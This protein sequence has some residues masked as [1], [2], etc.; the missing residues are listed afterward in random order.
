[1]M[2]TCS[3]DNLVTSDCLDIPAGLTDL[4][5]QY[6][7]FPEFRRALI[8]AIAD[9]PELAGWSAEGEQD[10]GVMLLEM[11]AYVLDVTQ[12]YD[13]QITQEFFLGT[14][15]RQVS[16]E[17]LVKLLG[18]RPRPAVSACVLLTAEADGTEPVM[19]PIGTAFRSD[20][21]GEEAPQV[22]STLAE[23]VIL[24]GRNGWPLAPIPGETYPGR[25]LFSE[26]DAGVPKS[27]MMAFE[28]AGGADHADAIAGVETIT[29]PDGARYR[30]VTLD[31]GAPPF[32]GRALA[33]IKPW[34]M[35]L[36]VG[37]TAFGNAV[38]GGKLI[39]DGLY[40][41]IRAGQIVVIETPDL[42]E[43][44]VI[45]PNGVD[46]TGVVV[47][48]TPALTNPE[49]AAQ[50]ITAPATRIALPALAALLL[51]ATPDFVLHVAPIAVGR[52][53]APARTEIALGDVTGGIAL[54]APR[55][56][57]LSEQSGDFVLTGHGPLGVPLGGTVATHPVT[58]RITFSAATGSADFPADLIAPLTLRGNLV[59]ATRGARVVG[60]VIG[61][62]DAGNPANRFKLKKKPLSWVEDGSAP[63][64]IRPLL[65]VRVDGVLWERVTTLYTAGP[66]DRVYML[67]RD[68]KASTWVVFG[69]RGKGEPPQTGTGN[70]TATY[71]Y[72]AGG[73]KPPPGAIHQIARPVQGLKSVLGSLLASGGQD[74]E[75]REDL[76]SNAP[77]AA[78]T[79]GRAVSVQDFEALARTYTGILNV[80]AGWAWAA[81]R[82]AASVSVRYIGD[83][84]V[85]AAALETWL[86]AQ[87]APGLPI[88]AEVA[89]NDPHTLTLGLA[90]DAA[91]PTEATRAAVKAA[92][93]DPDTGI[94]APR[95][96]RIGGTLFHSR[97][98][99][100]A[101]SVAGVAA[102]TSLLLDGAP[103]EWARRSEAGHYPDFYSV[104]VV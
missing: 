78:L 103:F 35:G 23:Q 84:G 11:W 59:A 82:Q 25:L 39:L 17:R 93:V 89:K 36:K 53:R 72:G 52:L 41:Q 96:V 26:T 54:Q 12:F 50:D 6:L 87:A 92:L 67:E 95:N 28:V 86:A 10:L 60:E 1:M 58:R 18:Y 33:D 77:A 34:L 16:T 5:R 8:Q 40:P 44:F 47:G 38:A 48:Q 85:D 80:R 7:G 45:A 31:G 27:G 22:F 91:H 101:Q 99:K 75:S 65:E 55:V 51:A 98:V 61:S 21:F 83:G 43:T 94:L 30:E 32:G 3:C 73:A 42:R 62:A 49:V 9:H 69:G 56:P 70:V 76:A 88:L 2:A 57:S 66:G 19:L 63:D 24:P 100:A 46:T 81:R 4:P 97:I 71:S 79:L 68:D 74:A 37:P 14:A 102:V 13:A 29:G 20:A 15:K 64:G 104:T 90:I